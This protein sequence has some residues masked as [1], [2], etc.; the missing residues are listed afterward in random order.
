MAGSQGPRRCP[1]GAQHGAINGAKFRGLSQQHSVRV[2]GGI[3]IRAPQQTAETL[4]GRPDGQVGAWGFPKSW[5]ARSQ[6]SLLL[7]PA[8]RPARHITLHS[9]RKDMSG[10]DGL[11]VEAGRHRSSILANE[12]SEN[13]QGIREEFP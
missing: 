8:A 4:D 11:K 13:S 5:D 10:L 6:V 9:L 3:R 7:S 12:A 2:H 1:P